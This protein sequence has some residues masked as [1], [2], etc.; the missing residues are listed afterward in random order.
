MSKKIVLGPTKCFKKILIGGG[1]QRPVREES[2]SFICTEII[3]EH[4]LQGDEEDGANGIHGCRRQRANLI[5]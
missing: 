1:R 5:Y 4:A 3:V 2:K